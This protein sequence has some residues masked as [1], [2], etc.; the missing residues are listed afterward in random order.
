MS[1]HQ[2]KDGRWIVQ[3]RDKDTGKIKRE[4]FGRGAEAEKAA[5]E[6][7]GELNLR[8]YKKVVQGHSAFFVDLANEY[9]AAK[10]GDNQES[11]LVK[12]MYKMDRVILPIIGH[13]RAMNIT[14]RKIDQYKKTRIEAGVKNT[15][16]RRELADIKAVLNWATERQYIAFNPI[17]K[18][19][20]PERDDAIF[21]PPSFDEIKSILNHSPGRLIRAISLSYYTGLR[22]GRR[23]LFSLKWTDVDFSTGTILVR[24]AKKGGLKYRLVP[25]HPNFIDVIKGWYEKD[26]SPDGPIIHYKGRAVTSLKK[27][28]KAAKIKAGIAR[29][30]RMY[31][32]RHA[33]AS[34]LL[35]NH[36]DL[37][38]T[39]QL[40]GHSRT[41]TTTRIYQHVDFDMHKDAI[42]RLPVINLDIQESITSDYQNLAN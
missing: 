16:I 4:Y 14:P 24:S 23:E 41:D 29:R 27:S 7:N 15:T 35:K 11:T 34:L 5:F 42:N 37:K 13:I 6:R 9:A 19:K 28:F 21:M 10:M 30:L 26:D 8:D 33:F 25:I 2:L 22:P 32:F 1:V 20:M 36:A 12:L 31:D 18:Y 38:S 39:S 3:H 40:L 17:E